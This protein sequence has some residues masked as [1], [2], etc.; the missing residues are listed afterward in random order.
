M[1]Y[2]Q[3]ATG[4]Q[5]ATSTFST[6]KSTAEFGKGQR[7][8]PTMRIHPTFWIF[9]LHDF[10]QSIVLL[11]QSTMTEE[12]MRIALYEEDFGCMPKGL[13][14]GSIPC[15]WPLEVLFL[16]RRIN[17]REEEERMIGFDPIKSDENEQR[18]DGLLLPEEA[19]ERRRDRLHANSPT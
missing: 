12:A 6:A 13:K 4:L 3:L 7:W 15:R 11:E 1:K 17:R 5:T 16:P 14:N 8:D 9:C 10:L 18:N 2:P 19:T